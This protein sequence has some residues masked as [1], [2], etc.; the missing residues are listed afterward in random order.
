MSNSKNQALVEVYEEIEFKK[1][2]DEIV[3]MPFNPMDVDL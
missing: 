1:K 3:P 2:S